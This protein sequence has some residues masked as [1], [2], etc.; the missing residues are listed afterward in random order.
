NLAAAL[1]Q[2]VSLEAAEAGE[3]N[4]V[5]RQRQLNE[6]A[7]AMI[8]EY[9]TRY[10]NDLA[11][12]Q[13]ECDMAARR[14]DFTRAVAVTHEIDKLAKAASLG[15]LLRARLFTVLNKPRELAEAY[16]EALERERGPR[17]LDLR[18]LLGQTQLR[19]GEVDQAL[20][21]ASLVLDVEK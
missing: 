15:P 9:R 6:Q 5:D 1:V 18:I 14:G 17:Q 20:R 4:Q 16:T 8:R 21:Q 2:V 10:P 13:A 11:F 19:L 7:A 12:L 3:W